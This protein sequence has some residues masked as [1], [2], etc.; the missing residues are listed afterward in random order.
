MLSKLTKIIKE[1]FRGLGQ[2]GYTLIEIAAVVAITATL[3]AV[4]VP[5]A[6]DKISKSKEAAAADDVKALASAVAGFYGDVGLW[7]ARSGTSDNYL[8]MLRTGNS[9]DNDPGFDITG[10]SYWDFSDDKSDFAQDHLVKNTH[11]Y[12][13]W[14]GPYVESL[15]DED[16]RD[17]WGHNYVIWVRGMW[18]KNST[19]GFGWVI[20][21]GQD[22]KLQT[23][24]TDDELKGDDIGTAIYRASSS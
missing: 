1:G 8:Y 22:G 24:T 2:K 5:V 17:P 23:N 11:S 4:V 18:D 20:S 19:A 12:A 7:P 3:A 16:K 15:K 6:M 10:T 14:A 9:K 21:A 13:N